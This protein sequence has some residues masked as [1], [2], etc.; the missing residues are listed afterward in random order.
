MTNKIFITIIY[1]I[2]WRAIIQVVIFCEVIIISN[3]AQ[4]IELENQEIS[5]LLNS[6]IN[7]AKDIDIEKGFNTEE[8]RIMTETYMGTSNDSQYY[9]SVKNYLNSTSGFINLGKKNQSENVLMSLII[10]HIG[11]KM[12]MNSYDAIFGTG[13]REDLIAITEDV[14][15]KCLSTYNLNR[16][17]KLKQELEDKINNPKHEIDFQNLKSF[18]AYLYKSVGRELLRYTKKPGKYGPNIETVENFVK[19]DQYGNKE[20]VQKTTLKKGPYIVDKKLSPEELSLINVN[21][22]LEEVDKHSGDVTESYLYKHNPL[23]YNDCDLENVCNDAHT[24]LLR[25]YFKEIFEGLTSEERLLL[26]NFDEYCEIYNIKKLKQ[27]EIA[28]ILNVNQGTVS[29]NIGNLCFKIANEIFKR[30]FVYEENSFA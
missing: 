27:A 4:E 7:C 5:A 21:T 16:D 20:Q 12:G 6:S 14:F 1:S 25:Q 13:T 2:I 10:T 15:I 17:N 28:K 29:K 3:S 30:G 9:T 18:N 26:R 19:I 24:Q 23:V 22:F 8:K 11:F